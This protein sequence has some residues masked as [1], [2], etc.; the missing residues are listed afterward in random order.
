MKLSKKQE[1]AIYIALDILNVVLSSGLDRD[2]D[3]LIGEAID[4]LTK[5][6]DRSI[7]SKSK[8]KAKKNA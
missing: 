2:E 1:I 4:E 5:M 3:G 8:E 6:R 7:I